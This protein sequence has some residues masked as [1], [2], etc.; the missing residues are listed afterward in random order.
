M[1]EIGI[2]NRMGRGAGGVPE[3]LTNGSRS[4]PKEMHHSEVDDNKTARQRSQKNFGT[5][6][7]PIHHPKV[8]L[9]IAEPLSSLEALRLWKETS[10]T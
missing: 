10:P 8:I 3:I 4:K 5:K 1:S 6:A 9:N 2:G 7:P